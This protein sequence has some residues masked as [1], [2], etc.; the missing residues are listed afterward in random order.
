VSD[1][2]PETLTMPEGARYTERYPMAMA[3]AALKHAAQE[4]KDRWRTPYIGHPVA[5]SVLVWQHAEPDGRHDADLTEDLAIAALL[6]DVAEDAG[7]QQALEEIAALFGPRV[8]E[9]VDRCSDALPASGE[10][11]APWRQR[12]ERHIEAIAR[13]ADPQSQIADP[14]ACLVIGCDKLHNLGETAADVAARGEAAL[15]LFNG[16]V[17]GTRWYYRSLR[18][19]LAPALPE[20]LLAGIDAQLSVIGA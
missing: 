5:V 8:A 20:R 14:G 16:G 17:D 15:E 11:K 6:H 19:V 4:R 9:I 7:G 18:D 12:K 10:A 3:F 13:L 2:F 1:G